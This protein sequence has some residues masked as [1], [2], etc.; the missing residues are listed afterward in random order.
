MLRLQGHIATTGFA[1]LYSFLRIYG[2]RLT[3]FGLEQAPS[4]LP[5]VFPYLVR[6]HHLEIGTTLPSILPM[7]LDR[8]PHSVA[9]ITVSEFEPDY[10]AY[11]RLLNFFL[12][13]RRIDPVVANY[14]Q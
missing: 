1:A 12:N 4:T 10:A 3:V 2:P 6:L 14:L 13:L 8:L 7:V 5:F 11:A 9:D